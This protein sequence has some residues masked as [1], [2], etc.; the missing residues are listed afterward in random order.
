MRRHAGGGD[1]FSL[2]NL[3]GDLLVDEFAIHVPG[4]EF[5]PGNPGLRCLRGRGIVAAVS[6][7]RPR[8]LGVTGSNGAVSFS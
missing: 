1:G 7:R 6:D 4:G 5:S 3:R 8:V 2:L